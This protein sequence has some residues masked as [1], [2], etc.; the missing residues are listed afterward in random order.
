MEQ[1]TTLSKPVIYNG[2]TATTTDRE[3]L[4][5]CTYVEIMRHEVIDQGLYCEFLVPDSECSDG[6]DL[7]SKHSRFTLSEV[8]NHVA[9][10][11]TKAD[12]FQYD[13]YQWSGKL[14]VSSFHP[15]LQAKVIQEVGVSAAGQ[16]LFTTAMKIV[17]SGEHFEQLDQL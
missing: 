10:Q 3:T 4:K 1:C 16:V 11:M 2:V 15:E 9:Q 12:D 6:W 8:K 13:N 5:H 7:F 17:F 14:I